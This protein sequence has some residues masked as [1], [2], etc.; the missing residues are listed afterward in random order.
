[1]K[2]Q[3]IPIHESA[4]STLGFL[5][6]KAWASDTT[7]W[8]TYASTVFIFTAQAQKQGIGRQTFDFISRIAWRTESR[9]F[10]AIATP[11]TKAPVAFM[12]KW[13]V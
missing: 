4:I 9:H 11:T 2:A 1:M 3:F 10:A 12:R 6:Q 7:V 8:R 13:A 5:C